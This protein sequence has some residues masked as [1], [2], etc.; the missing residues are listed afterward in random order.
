[1]AALA[2]ARITRPDESIPARRVTH[3][4]FTGM[5]KFRFGV[6]RVGFVMS[7][8]CPVYPKQQTFPDSVD[9]SQLGQGR[10]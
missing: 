6:I 8:V 7:V 2:N 5:H 4:R 3:D 1:M 10:T 9:T